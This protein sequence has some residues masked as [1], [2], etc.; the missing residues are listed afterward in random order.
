MEDPGSYGLKSNPTEAMDACWQQ[1]LC[2]WYWSYIFLSI[3]IMIPFSYFLFI[4]EV[5]SLIFFPFLNLYAWKF[6]FD[7]SH[8]FQLEYHHQSIFLTYCCPFSFS[9]NLS[10]IQSI[11]YFIHS[12]LYTLCSHYNHNSRSPIIDMCTQLHSLSYCSFPCLAVS[13]TSFIC[14]MVMGSLF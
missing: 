14:L 11:L 5:I 13:T 1:R 10:L 9:H 7:Q 2:L 12:Y 6:I 8:H 3:I 4:R